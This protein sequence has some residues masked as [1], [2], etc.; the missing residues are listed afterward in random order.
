MSRRADLPIR[1]FTHMR[2]FPQAMVAID[3]LKM[4]GSWVAPI[5]RARGWTVGELAEMYREDEPDLLGLNCERGEWI[6]LRLRTHGRPSE[7]LPL[8]TIL[9]TLLHELAHCAYM[10]HNDSFQ[11]LWEQLREEMIGILKFG[12]GGGLS[13][14][15]HSTLR[16]SASSINRSSFA[17]STDPRSRSILRGC[18]STS[19]GPRQIREI[20]DSSRR[21]SIRTPASE[22]VANDA[23]VSQNF[24]NLFQQEKEKKYGSSYVRPSTRNPFG[25][26]AGSS[27]AG[28][29]SSY[30]G[31]S[32]RHSS[33]GAGSTRTIT[34]SRNSAASRSRQS[35]LSNSRLSAAP[36]SAAGKSQG[37]WACELCTLHNAPPR[38]LCEAC[39]GPR[40][41]RF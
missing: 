24:W 33:S 39:R 35:T 14:K 30:S 34:P 12:N 19:F 8:V 41:S 37:S 4:M 15:S 22:D 6:K 3:L 28:G 11:I 10:D 29:S 25:S 36:S 16:S 26:R 32:S 21:S 2:E 27:L 17:P 5:M 7:F 23:A 18:A 20:H 13:S 9:D 40:P 1:A 31:S 38:A